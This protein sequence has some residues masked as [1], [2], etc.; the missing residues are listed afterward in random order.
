MGSLS[1]EY[2]IAIYLRLSRDD[3][4]EESQSIQSQREMLTSYINGQGWEIFKEY[5]DDGFSGTN[6]NRPNFQRLIDDIER[7]IINMVITKD[8]SRLGRNYIQVGYYTEDYF[9]SKNVRYIA[10]NDGYDSINEDGND[11]VPLRNFMNEWYAKDTS[12][13]IR[14]ILNEKAKNGEPKRTCFPIYGYAFNDKNERVPDSETAPTVKLIFDKFIELGSIARVVDYLKEKKI[15]TPSYYNAIKYKYNKSKILSL[16][17]ASNY[18]WSAETVREIIKRDEYLG[19]YRTAQTKSISF[20]NKKRFENKDC[21]VFE[22]RYA[23]IVDKDTWELAQ[24][25]LRKT[26]GS[27]ISIQEN[28]FKGLIYCLDCGAQMRLEK[29]GNRKTNQFDYRYYCYHKECTHQNSIPKNLLENIIKKELITLKDVLLSNKTEFLDFALSYK[30]AFR[31][32][33]LDFNKELSV[34]SLRAEE[35]NGFIENLISQHSKGLIP[36]STLTSLLEKY[37]REK[38]AIDIQ[39]QKITR[40][41][42]DEQGNAT[43]EERAEEIIDII[44][45][46]E[47]SNILRIEIVQRLLSKIYIRTRYVSEKSREREVDI[48]MFYRTYNE[49][50]KGFLTND[51]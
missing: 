25:L 5:V 41:M 46:V 27:S 48:T 20:K 28:I 32:I 16:P 6:F 47:E 13:K 19:V 39:L 51:K 9:P 23:P 50:I 42:A 4:S 2:R 11:F 49:I 38:S 12:K 31:R 40:K 10:V 17:E 44:K 36:Q 18:N 15:K 33:S 34:L 30:P 22:N 35:I 3:G 26:K 21:F 45:S 14:A 1:N 43:R 24:T 8:L 7:G 37:Q 29:R